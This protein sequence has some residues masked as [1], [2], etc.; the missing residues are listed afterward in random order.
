MRYRPI[1]PLARSLA[2]AALGALMIGGPVLAA[3]APA[4][5]QGET[6]STL[7][8]LQ[9][10]HRTGLNVVIQVNSADTM[11]NGVSKQIL[12]AKNLY[13]QYAGLGLKPG[14]DFDIVMVF[15]AD[16]AQFLLND[17]AYDA[18]VKTPHAPG[19]PSRHFLDAMHAG[20]VKMYE[21]AVSMRGKGYAPAD[22]LPYARPV[23]S[24]IGA[25]VDFEKSGYL[26]MTP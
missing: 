26:P 20:G 5:V 21:C 9:I 17:G 16:G 3:D 10:T 7:P 25:L 8:P 13:D 4:A 1:S 2:V 19:N 12:A 15:R 22:L 24:G 6:E 18:K 14:K 11:M 23:A